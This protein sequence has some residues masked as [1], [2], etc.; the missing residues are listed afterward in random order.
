MHCKQID[1]VLK[2]L[3]T[4]ET[5][6]QKSINFGDEFGKA[7]VN[8]FGV[9]HKQTKYKKCYFYYFKAFISLE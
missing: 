8:I 3:L 4:L 5:G 1:I 6:V 7:S 2:S 9:C